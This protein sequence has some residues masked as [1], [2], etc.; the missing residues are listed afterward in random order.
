MLYRDDATSGGSLRVG[1]TIANNLDPGRIEAHLVFA[2]GEP[3]GVSE[4]AKVN[5]HHLRARSSKDLPRWFLARALFKKLKP[6]IIHFVDPVNWIAIATL[7]IGAKHLLHFHGRPI[8]RLMTLSDRCLMRARRRFCDGFV[9]ITCGAINSAI[10]AGFAD[11]RCSWTVYNG[12]DLEFFEKLPPKEAAREALKLPQSAK[13]I[14]QV[15]RLVSYNGGPELL[16]VLSLLPEEWQAVFVGDGPF[17]AELQ[18]LGREKGLDNKVHF[19]GALEDVRPAYASLDAVALMARYQSFCFMIAEAMASGVAVFGLLGDGEYTESPNPLIA[20]DNSVFVV[21]ADPQDY[22][23][24]ESPE[25]VEK[26]AKKI[27][28]F[29]RHPEGFS[30]M[31]ETAHGHVR[32]RF[33]ARQQSESI[34]R[35]YFE[36]IG[37]NEFERVGI[38]QL[39]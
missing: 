10:E 20:A 21:R 32:E 28:E 19:T 34:T 31:I 3:G 37:S 8:T 22:E 26:L 35:V 27:A 13:L 29:G 16:D 39:V 5:V 2:Y 9:G 36:L 7:G 23:S 38:E 15:A 6:D 17:R 18:E 11:P 12:V 25:V 24:I 30:G 14:G 33:S 4:N 1:E